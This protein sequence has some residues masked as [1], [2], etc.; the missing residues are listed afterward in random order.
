MRDEHQTRHPEHETL[1][2]IFTDLQ[3]SSRNRPIIVEGSKDIESLEGMGLSTVIITLNQGIPIIDLC[4]RIAYEF[5]E[6]VIL[7]D[8]DAK[9]NSLCRILKMY[10]KAND[11]RYDTRIRGRLAAVMKRDVKDV[12]GI[13][14]FLENNFPDTITDIRHQ[15]A[16]FREERGP[17]PEMGVEGFVSGR[18]PGRHGVGA[19]VDHKTY[20]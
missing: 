3:E 12:E 8:W 4:T 17:E 16:C 7:T 6:V 9:G 5:T 14:P 13:L 15:L 18:N 10:L 19:P 1:L 20:T 11:L 2:S